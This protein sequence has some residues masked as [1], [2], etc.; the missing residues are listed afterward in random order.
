MT[1]T[2][3]VTAMG[4]LATLLGAWWGA[5]WQHRNSRDLQLL[6]ARVRVYGECAASLY[7]FERVTYSRVKARLADL[8]A[9]ERESL[10]Q[11]A[12]RNNSAARAAIGQLSILSA[13]GK[14]PKGFE[15]LRQAIG[16]LND[17]PGLDELRER[18]DEIYVELDRVLEQ[19]RADLAR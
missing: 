15:A 7:E 16:D 6:D 18:H 2:V 4:I 12:Y 10:R 9:A 3:V 1:T 5:Y 8:P 13:G 19:A 11:E 14:I 17:A